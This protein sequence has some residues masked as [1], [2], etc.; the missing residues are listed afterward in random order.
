MKMK[1]NITSEFLK[2]AQQLTNTKQNKIIMFSTTKN[3]IDNTST[4]NE[5]INKINETFNIELPNSKISN[6]KNSGRCW[7][8]CYFKYVKI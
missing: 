4:N 2:K 5:V 7:L 8:F 6:Q 1:Q 3:G